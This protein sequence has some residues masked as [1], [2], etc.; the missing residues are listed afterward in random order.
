M[1]NLRYTIDD[2]RG[3]C[4]VGHPVPAG[5]VSLIASARAAGKGL[6]TL[7]KDAF[8]PAPL[9]LC[10]SAMIMIFLTA[11]H[12]T[13]APA[14]PPTNDVPVILAFDY[15]TND[16][17]A[18]YAFRIYASTNLSLPVSQ[19]P[20]LTNCW[21]TN[22]VITNRSSDASTNVGLQISLPVQPG[23]RWFVVT[24]SNFWGESPFSNVTAAPALPRG[25][26]VLRLWRGW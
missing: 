7:P 19:W 22:L 17:P 26:V 5:C 20:L 21:L 23:A 6:H 15:P 10:V 12:L 8:F 11:C 2:L 18:V 1:K 3:Y 14:L 4:R 24:A 9:R 13:A 25:D 16:L